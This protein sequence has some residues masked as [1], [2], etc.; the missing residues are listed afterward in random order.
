MQSAF[1]RA[2]IHHAKVLEPLLGIPGLYDDVILPLYA[3]GLALEQGICG[4]SESREKSL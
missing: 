2:A 1:R 4:Y 3:H